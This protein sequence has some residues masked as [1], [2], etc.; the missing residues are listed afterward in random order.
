VKKT[1]WSDLDH[2][3]W[4]S[5]REWPPFKRL[6]VAFSGGVDSVVLLNVIHRLSS[7]GQFEFIAAHVHH[8]QAENQAWRD[9]ALEWCRDYCVTKLGVSF[10]QGGPSPQPLFS[11]ES[12]REYRYHELHRLK[13]EHECDLILTAHHFDD[14]LETRILRL[15]RGTGPAGLSSMTSLEGDLWRPL[16]EV[17]RSEIMEYAKKNN[18]TNLED[19]S[20]SSLDPQRN[21]VRHQLLPFI[22]NRQR[23][24]TANLGRSLQLLVEA[25]EIPVP[26]ELTIEG[27]SRLSFARQGYLG[28][29]KS[30]QRRLL[31]T[32]LLKLGLRDYSQGQIEEIHKRLDNSQIVHTFTFR[33]VLWAIDARQVRAE[34]ISHFL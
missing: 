8:G 27:Q 6:L 25:M 7:A 15:L 26:L 22:E 5:K 30:D 18:L 23:G 14:L 11:E 34:I 28:L 19:P 17:S 9:E 29:S 4:K 16:L 33:S 12:L 24:L 1:V 21:W 3:I 20:N 31:A 13:L 2:K 32:V 10:V